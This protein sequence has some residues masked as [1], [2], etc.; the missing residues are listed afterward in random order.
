MTD[1]VSWDAG[2]IRRHDKPGPLYTAYPPP[3]QYCDG[4]LPGDLLAAL[5]ESARQGRP[6]SLS[7]HVPFCASACHFCYCTRV[8]TKDRSRAQSYL[9]ALYREIDLLSSALRPGAAVDRL[10]LGGGTP[11]FFSHQDLTQMMGRLRLGFN[12]HDDDIGDYSVEID[13]READWS[14]LGLLRELGFN[15]VVLGVPDLDPEV[16]RAINRL[17]S[18]EETQ[19]VMDAARTLAYR[20]VHMHLMY[21]LPRQTVESF[22][23]TLA[24]V[25]DMQPDR[26][27]LCNYIHLP[28]RYAS[29]RHIST[30][31]LPAHDV[32]LAIYASS[33]AQLSAAGYRFI[34]VGQ[35]ALPDDSLSL[36]RDAD[37]LTYGLLGYVSGVGSDLVGLGVSAI[38]QV[39]DICSRNTCDIVEY[40]QQL[41]HGRL[42]LRQGLRRTA[43]DRL[44]RT[45][46]QQLLCQWRLNFREIEQRFNIDFASYF[47]DCYDRLRQM[48]DDGLI[49]LDATGLDVLPAGRLL[50][51]RICAVFDAYQHPAGEER[52]AQC[53]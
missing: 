46:I 11:T 5:K 7:V 20:S 50:V 28:E 45:L 17:Q 18:Q 22:A 19:A 29:Q 47:S 12:L 9:N 36:A 33:H 4:I 1:P 49:R 10:H 41:Q 37:T 52:Y 30:E 53:I 48:H 34:G 15:H 31:E 44:R 38:S 35:Y 51:V 14:T 8:I 13:P 25:I 43:D 26:L 39:G 24:S 16:Q 21:G 6:L 42:P 40:Q 2:L 27:T 23:R 32:R 3:A